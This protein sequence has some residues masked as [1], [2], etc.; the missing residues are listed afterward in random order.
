MNT[1]SPADN[2]PCRT[3]KTPRRASA[4]V[5]SLALLG[6]LTAMPGAAIDA[7]EAW[8][9]FRGPNGSGIGPAVAFPLNWTE[10]DYLWRVP[11]PG[12]GHSSPV[13]W[14]DLVIVQSGETEGTRRYVLAIEAATGRTR[15]QREFTAPAHELHTRNS[16]GSSTPA[17]DA[18][19]IFVV[20]GSPS[21]NRMTKISHAGETLWEVPLGPFSCPH[22]PAISP[23][24]IDDLVV[25]CLVQSTDEDRPDEE[26]PAADPFSAIVALD[27]ADGALRWRHALP[28]AK[29]SYSV[30]CRFRSPDGTETVV[31]C[32]HRV[33]MFGLESA[34]GS[35]QWSLP[36][37]RQRTVSSP[38]VAGNRLLGT[39]GSG[40]GGNDLVAVQPGS[41]PREVYRVSQQAP[42][43][44]TPI[45][46][47]GL[48]YLWSDKG[49]ACCLDGVTGRE[50][51]KKRVGGPVSAS[52]VCAGD[53]LIGVSEDGDVIVLS[54]SSSFEVLGGGSLGEP[55]HATPAV[56]TDAIYFRSFTQLMALGP[57][58]QDSSDKAPT[59]AAGP[60]TQ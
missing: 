34:S 16:Y 13:L 5:G 11:I 15:W 23:M 58:R 51:W 8:N 12:K 19:G 48:V 35:L 20:W 56:G 18:H 30:P 49:I 52:P 1:I 59:S 47:D 50:H 60:P 2:A 36:V 28:A 37:F 10:G 32:G 9:R 45:Y 31:C 38:I 55:S 25:C 27:A 44:P 40:G 7:A 17:V 33:G 29:S 53:R 42:Y 26:A 14:N 39:N 24:L 3:V 41:M 21:D 4:A 6:L 46:R 57:S 22:G 54:A 43:V